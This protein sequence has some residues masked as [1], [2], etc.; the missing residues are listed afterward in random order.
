[1]KIPSGEK[2]LVTHIDGKKRYLITRTAD[3]SGYVGYEVLENNK[4][5]RLGKRKT[6]YEVEDLFG[7]DNKGEDQ[8]KSVRSRAKKMD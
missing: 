1:M 5:K 4:L 8:K 2:L 3:R 6:P 7:L